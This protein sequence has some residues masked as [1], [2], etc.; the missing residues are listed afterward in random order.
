[1]IDIKSD[2]RKVKQGDIFVALKGF[3]SNGDEY[4]EK[5]IEN[6][7]SK[8]ITETNNTYSVETINVEN[9]RG[10]LVNYLKDN[11]GKYLDE[12]NIIGI[13]GTNGKTTTAYLIYQMLNKLNIKCAYIGTIGY[14]LDKKEYS[15]P[16]T[17]PDICEIYD[18]LV[19]AYENGYK[20]VVMEVSSQGL[21]M[22]RLDSIKFNYALFTNLTQDHLDYHKTMENYAKAKQKLFYNLKNNGVSIINSDDGYKDYFTISNYVEYGFNNNDYKIQE[23]NLGYKINFKLNI[24]GNIYNIDSKLIG[25]YNMYNLVGAITLL[26]QMNI[27]ITDILN[28]VKDV[29]SP[30][31]RTDIINYN[32]NLIIVDYAHTPDAMENIYNLVNEIKKGNVYTVFGC[33]GDRDRTKRPIMMRIATNNS[34]HVIF[35]SDDLHDEDFG[36]IVSDTINGIEN[37][38][39]EV[40]M[41]RGKAIENGISLLKEND[42]LLV[43]GKGH[44]E[45]IIIK[46]KKIPFNDKKVIEMLIES[47]VEL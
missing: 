34:K 11:Y 37:T 31:G 44:E 12:M 22:G 26:H 21:D 24:H 20:T 39:F 46:D 40:I 18:M 42:I 15:L 33:T 4:V 17:S 28:V 1:M 45:F 9:S 38:N 43:L 27:N 30:P 16:N 2:S 47:V 5:A 32:N 3:S 36:R 29:S 23:Y 6:G 19:N 8:I 10:Y 14:Y 35:T 25:K 41:N 7:A 13:T